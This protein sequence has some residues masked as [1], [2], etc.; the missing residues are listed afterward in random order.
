MSLAFHASVTFCSEWQH[1]I[2]ATSQENFK[3]RLSIESQRSQK[4]IIHSP[5]SLLT[6]LPHTNPLG[7][8]ALGPGL[9]H[10]VVKLPQVEIR[11]QMK[12]GRRQD[13]EPSD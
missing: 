5:A 10:P 9:T 7:R 4:S 12:A 3:A 1:Q 11:E 8:P 2:A 6:L 13:R